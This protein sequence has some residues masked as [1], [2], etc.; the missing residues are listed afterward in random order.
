MDEIGRQDHGAVAASVLRRVDKLNNLG[1]GDCPGAPDDGRPPA[2]RVGA[3]A[4][5]RLAFVHGLGPELAGAAVGEQARAAVTDTQFHIA[6]IGRLVD[7]PLG[8]EG[9]H[10]GDPG[11]VPVDRILVHVI[12]PEAR[13]WNQ[14]VSPGATA[15]QRRGNTTSAVPLVARSPSWLVPVI[16]RLTVPVP[17]SFPVTLPR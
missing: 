13:S 1:W 6:P 8:V 9:R 5:D 12:L 17:S 3:K 4:H 11:S 7:A 15:H 16:S 2:R 10:Q 14:K